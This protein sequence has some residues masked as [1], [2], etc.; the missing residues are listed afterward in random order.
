MQSFPIN[1]WAVLVA[2]LVKIV[3]GAVWYSPIAFLPQWMTAVGI[4]EAHMKRAFP[5]AIGVDIVGALVMAYV[6]VHAVHYAGA[7]TLGQGAAIGFFG[8]L[9]FIGLVTLG[10]VIYENRPMRHYLI[11]NAYL[12]ISLLIM[13]AILAVWT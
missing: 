7:H 11:N 13:G 1:W 3:L 10:Q 5:K 4:G 2:A 6:L 12:L 9:G 8:W